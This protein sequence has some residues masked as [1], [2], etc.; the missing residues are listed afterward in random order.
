MSWGRISHPSDMFA[1]GDEVEVMI[2]DIEKEKGRVSLGLKQKTEN[3]WLKIQE[4]YPVG[5]RVNGVVVNMTNYG[6]FVEIQQGVEGLIH[7]SEMSWTKRINHP[8][9]VLNIGDKVEAVVLNVNAD[10][11]KIS[12]GLKQ[13][14]ENPWGKVF[15]KYTV[16]SKVKGP[17]RNITDYGVFIE[18]ENG[19]DGLIHIS[20]MSWTKRINHP[21]ELFQKGQ[22]VKAVVL[23]V[24]ADNKKISLGIK[25]LS[26]DPWQTIEDRYSIGQEVKGV[27][28]RITKFGIFVALKKDTIEG[29]IHTSQIKLEQGKT[30]EDIYK[31]GEEI[32]GYISNLDVEQRKLGIV[33]DKDFKAEEIPSEDEDKSKKKKVVIE[34]PD[35]TDELQEDK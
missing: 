6:A 35:L 13:I 18:L 9:E 5:G 12:L 4:K 25:Q 2:L 14:E 24:N 26:D 32:V 31:E 23:N 34:N 16:N 29:L 22:E 28:S 8:S 11:Q 17:V 21:S 20:D 10:A 33:F 7:V 19:I 27:I 30:L 15:E 1:I 3:P